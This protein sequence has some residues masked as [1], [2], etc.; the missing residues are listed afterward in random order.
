[1]LGAL[2]ATLLRAY[3][4]SR[5]GRFDVALDDPEGAQRAVLARIVRACA[6]TGYGRSLGLAPDDDLAA[7]RRKV[8][9]AGYADVAPWIERQRSGE[10]NALSPGTTR[11]YEPTSGSGG[12]AKRIP[13]NDAMLAAFRSLFALWVHDVLRHL[14]RP[15]SGRTF[16]S[17][18]PPLADADGF[19]DDREYLGTAMRALVGRFL[20]L[21]PR[22][23]DAAAFRDALALA[24][25]SAAD[26]EIVS[27]W[28]PSYLA[29]LMDHLEADRGRLLLRLPASRRAPFRGDPVQW[30]AVWPRLQLVSC[31]SDANA[32]PAA[33]MLAQ[34]LPHAKLQGKGLLATEAPVTLPLTAAGGC[35]PLVDEIFIEL[36][37]E[38]GVPR[39]LWDAPPDAE[40]EVVIT[41]P[42]GLLRY[43]LG[44]RVAV[45]GRHRA[46]P[47]LAFIGRADAVCD[48]VGE[49]L[50]EPFVAAVLARTLRAGAFATLLPLAAAR[51][52]ARYCLLTDDD[53]PGLARAVEAALG[54]AL[55][56]REARAL[57][58]L[59]SLRVVVRADMRR[60]VHDALAADGLKAGDIKDRAL[61]VSIERAARIAQR[62][63]A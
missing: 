11:A 1:V 12:A 57:G 27:V 43:R 24:L 2:A 51:G 16:M 50:A 46:T 28:N 17:V 39:A 37:D 61:E 54:A 53:A 23:A 15:Q 59:D 56:Y 25:A 18:S 49:K 31:W 8:P 41:Q 40:Y 13:Y 34:R 7:F 6:V 29:I 4:A 60:A 47:V 22:A 52:P 55:R 30:D 35:V 14:V 36:I 9:L 45:R 58:Q 26:L 21:P 62:I 5:A 10:A 48:L 38:H 44:D 19:A 33:R 63:A 20:V 32:A 42:G 3:C